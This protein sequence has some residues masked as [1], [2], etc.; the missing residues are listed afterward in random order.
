MRSKPRAKDQGASKAKTLFARKPSSNAQSSDAQC[1]G[2]QPPKSRLE[3]QGQTGPAG[4]FENLGLRCKTLDV[5]AMATST[6]DQGVGRRS[7]GGGGGG[8]HRLMHGTLDCL[9]GLKRDYDNDITICGVE[10]V[11]IT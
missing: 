9:M 1:S 5:C 11:G 8:Q 7:P 4:G 6:C 2:G 3:R 10:V